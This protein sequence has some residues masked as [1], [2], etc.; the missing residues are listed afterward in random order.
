[1]YLH[2]L[3][4]QPV[5]ALAQQ[6][7]LPKNLPGIIIRDQR[8]NTNLLAMVMYIYSEYMYTI[9]IIRVEA[10]LAQYWEEEICSKPKLWEVQEMQTTTESSGKTGR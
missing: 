10:S 2:L 7:W 9:I 3:V 1:M 8:N 5:L 4:L 6:V